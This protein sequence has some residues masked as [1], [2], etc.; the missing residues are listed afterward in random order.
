MGEKKW[1]E[2]SC[3]GE[4]KVGFNDVGGDLECN[5]CHFNTY[6]RVLLLGFCECGSDDAES[7]IVSVLSAIHRRSEDNR[8]G[9]K[10]S[11]WVDNTK[12]IKEVILSAS[13]DIIDEFVFHMLANLNLTEHGS[14][15]CGSWLSDRGRDVVESY[16]HVP[17]NMVHEGHR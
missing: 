6:R 3:G 4:L 8:A 7:W 17:L 5:E 9:C 11:S 14:N 2:C 13:P 16:K 10:E 12:K 15:V 1:F